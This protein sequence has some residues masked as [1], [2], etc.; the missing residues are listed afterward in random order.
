[1][2]QKSHSYPEVTKIEKDTCI[3][4][5]TAAQFIIARTRKKPGCP[6]MDEWIKKLWYTYTMEYSVKFSCSVVPYSLQCQRMQH[7]ELPCPSP[8][9][10]ACSNS[11]PLCRWCHSTISPLSSPSPPTFN[12]SQ[13]QDLFQWVSS[14]H[15]M[16]RVSSSASVLSMNIQDWFLL[17]CTG[18][19]FLLSERF[20]RGFSN[21]TVQKHH[22]FSN[23]T[24]QMHQFFSAQ[25][26]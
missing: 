2:T 20:W 16:A 6:S 23:T 24:V 4:L 18:W 26:S 5:F 25:L 8:T 11:C 19:I 13:Q 14:S 22:H 12:L 9:P 15:Q 10:R 21:T 3:P 1:M 17:G 7:A